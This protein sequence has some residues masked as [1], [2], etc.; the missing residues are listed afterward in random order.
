MKLMITTVD[1]INE[2]GKTIKSG[3]NDIL[4]AL[5]NDGKDELNMGAAEKILNKPLQVE[6]IREETEDELWYRLGLIIGKEKLNE[7]VFY[8][9]NEKY[10]ELSKTLRS[11]GIKTTNMNTQPRI[12]TGNTVSAK[13]KPETEPVTLEVTPKKRGRKPKVKAEISA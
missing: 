11:Q 1:Y 13:Q 9:D 10:K 7:A 4:L 8:T 5:Y 3:E 6:F 2:K 12:K